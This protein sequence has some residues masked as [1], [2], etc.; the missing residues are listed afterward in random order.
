MY[1]IAIRILMAF[2]LSLIIS[3]CDPLWDSY[4]KIYL[5]NETDFS[6]LVHVHYPHFNDSDTTCLVQTHA[7]DQFI[8]SHV[9]YGEIGRSS[10]AMDIWLICLYDSSC[11]SLS[12]YSSE[13]DGESYFKQFVEYNYVDQST[14]KNRSTNLTF[15][16][17]INDSLRSVMTKNTELADS[18]LKLLN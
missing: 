6:F 16:I 17:T 12:N 5:T 15:S 3:S 4:N 10:H 9:V 11:V 8:D 2:S 14:R 18:L 1:K 7:V 13:I